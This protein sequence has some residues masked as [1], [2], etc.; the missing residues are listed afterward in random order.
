LVANLV[1]RLKKHDT[2]CVSFILRFRNLKPQGSHKHYITQF[3][4]EGCRKIFKLGK[5]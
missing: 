3:S 5:V 1:E 4:F 2:Q